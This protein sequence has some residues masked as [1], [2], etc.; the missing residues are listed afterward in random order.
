M[1]LLLLLL[2]YKTQVEVTELKPLK[3]SNMFVTASKKA[4]RNQTKC[5]LRTDCQKNI[6]AIT[7]RVELSFK[8][9]VIYRIIL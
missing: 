9:F 4:Y 2:V 1:S 7:V 6:I 5:C 3:L 8:V